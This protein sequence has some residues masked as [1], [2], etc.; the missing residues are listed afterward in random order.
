MR[1]TAFITVI[2]AAFV[3]LV[4]SALSSAQPSATPGH[5]LDCGSQVCAR[6]AALREAYEGAPESWPA[7]HLDPDI[8]YVELGALP[9]PDFD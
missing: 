6:G 5:A 2:G 1:I 3:G 7:P 8:A 9:R 4:W